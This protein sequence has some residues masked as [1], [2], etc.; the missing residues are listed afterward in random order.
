M[1]MLEIKGLG[2]MNKETICRN[3]PKISLY[4][5]ILW[6]IVQLVL[7][8]VYWNYPQGPD[9]QGYMRHALQNYAIGSTYPSMLNLCDQFLHSP[10]MV[11]YLMLQHA[12]FGTTDFAIDKLFNIILNIGI[13]GNV[14]YLAKRFFSKNTAYLAVIIYC[15]MPTNIFAP[16]WHLSELPY[17]CLALTGF[18]LS[19]NKKY[20]AIAL[21]GALY[22]VAHT[23]RPLVLTFLFTSMALFWI[24]K[25]KIASYICVVIPYLLLLYA[26]GTHNKSNTGYF[27]TSSTTGGYNLIM[28]ANDNAHAWPE[29]ALFRDTSNIAYIPNVNEMT[30]AEKDSIYKARAIDWILNNPLRYMTLFAE[31]IGRLWSGDVWSVPPFSRWDNYDYIRV[32]PE[33][34][35]ARLVLIRRGIQAIEGIP[36]YALVIIFFYTLYRKRKDIFSQKGL[37][38]LIIL[39]G[40]AG[41]CL[42]T[43]EVRFHYPY[44]FCLILWAAYGLSISTNEREL[45]ISIM[46]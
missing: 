33:K 35:Q 18:S 38:L 26:V 37:F 32:Q 45:D 25:R 5:V 22:A 24:E 12:L 29:F 46:Q 14:Y 15:V 8:V 31:K 9:Q 2:K 19:L 11:N 27:V 17:L 43:V 13:L 36:Y 6:V 41:T 39:L 1:N 23:F 34:E 44:L 42:F 40:T 21:A 7:I 16:I 3:L 30:F 20:W 4:T 28:T 10:G